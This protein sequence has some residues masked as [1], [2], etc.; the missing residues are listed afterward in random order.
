MGLFSE[1][2]LKP[3]GRANSTRGQPD[4]LQFYLRNDFVDHGSEECQK[5]QPALILKTVL[6]CT[7][8]LYINTPPIRIAVLLVP[9]RSEEREIFNIVSVPPICIAVRLPFVLQ[10]ASHLYRSTFG[11]I[12]VVVVT[13]MFPNSV[14]SRPKLLQKILFIERRYSRHLKSTGQSL[15]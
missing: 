15:C 8:N 2:F 9:L 4:L 5:P 10:Y 7:S 6:E 12:V 11:K 14:P 1:P 3:I 13:G